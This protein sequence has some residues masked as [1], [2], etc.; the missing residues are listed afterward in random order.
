MHPDD[1]AGATRAAIAEH[2]GGRDA[3]ALA[4][5]IFAW[6]HHWPQSFTMA[7]GT[8]AASVTEWASGHEVDVNRYLKLR[9]IA[10][11]NLA[12]IL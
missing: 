3:D 2:P 10:L 7:L 11:E 12:R 8:D 9:R 1:L 4:A 6:Q 5:W